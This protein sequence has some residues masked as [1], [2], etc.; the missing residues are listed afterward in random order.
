MRTE[1][2]RITQATLY[3]PRSKA[4]GDANLINFSELYQAEFEQSFRGYSIKY[5]LQGEENYVVNGREHR[6]RAGEY[7]LTN[8]HCRGT[9]RVASASLVLGLCIDIRPAVL[10]DVLAT[11]GRYANEPDAPTGLT[12][13][14]DTVHFY[15]HRFA[16]EG[17][18]LGHLLQQ[19]APALGAQ[20]SDD[21]ENLYALAECYV[22]DYS[23][24]LR[25]LNALGAVRSA[26]RHELHRRLERGREFI[27]SS[28]TAPITVTEMARAA[29]LSTYRF[30][31]L[32]KQVYGMSP[33]R[34]MLQKRLDLG[35]DLLLAGHCTATEAAL[36]TGFADL[37]SFSKAFKQRF[38]V[39][40]GKIN[41]RVSWS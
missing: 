13:A 23:Q 15:E 8:P 31:R 34:F 33:Y 5:V 41:H 37:F 20:A 30:F 18:S 7:L 4:A 28:F 1:V 17:T 16:A 35:R 12:E 14:L 29:H 39:S 24:V 2:N 10:A 22:A 19:L 9:G 21:P 32:F 27:E 40:P 36:H 26:T 11:C 3:A 6:V 38:G 25:Q